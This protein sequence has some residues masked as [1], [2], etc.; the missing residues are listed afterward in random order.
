MGARHLFAAA[1]RRLDLMLAGADYLAARC[2]ARA[3]AFVGDAA[4]VA[5]AGPYAAS[6]S[7]RGPAG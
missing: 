5:E 7:A 6:A 1:D 2:A 4:P 3:D